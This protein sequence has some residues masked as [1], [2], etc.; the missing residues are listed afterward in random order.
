[1]KKIFL[2]CIHEEN[3]KFYAYVE[4]IKTG[5]NLNNYLNREKIMHLCESR[6]QADQLVTAWNC[7]FRQNKTYF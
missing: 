4:P 7:G 6:K 3:G 2:A 5:E 1:M